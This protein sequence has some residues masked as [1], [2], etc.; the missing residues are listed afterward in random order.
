M[1][2]GVSLAFPPFTRM[3]KT[4]IAVNVATGRVYAAGCNYGKSPL[5]CGVTAID[6]TSNVGANTVISAL[7]M[8]SRA[9]P[10]SSAIR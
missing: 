9:G 7:A 1:S 8:L 3:V 5:L 6:G 2:R 4:L 10:S